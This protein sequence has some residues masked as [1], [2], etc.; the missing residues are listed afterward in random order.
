[1]IGVEDVNVAGMLR[2]HRLAL[3]I[4]DAS[5]GESQRQ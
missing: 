4:A 5:F 2:N 3:S 1:M